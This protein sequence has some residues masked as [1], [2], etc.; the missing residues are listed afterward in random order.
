MAAL[1]VQLLGVRGQAISE[2]VS[3]LCLKPSKDSR[4]NHQ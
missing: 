3:N 4:N 2:G 1:N